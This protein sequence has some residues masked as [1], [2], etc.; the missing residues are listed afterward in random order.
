MASS[1]S[2][3]LANETSLAAWNDIQ[4]YHVDWSVNTF[5]ILTMYLRSSFPVEGKLVERLSGVSSCPGKCSTL[6]SNNV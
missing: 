1:H 2:P 6:L 3:H 4:T 5:E